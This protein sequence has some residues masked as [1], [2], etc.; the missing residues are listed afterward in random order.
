MF[1]Y[2]ENIA[3]EL[4]RLFA[5]LKSQRFLRDLNSE[6]FASKAA[7][8]LAELNG[9]AHPPAACRGGRAT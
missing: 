1:C 4:R 3:G 8:F 9:N 6:E 2:P 5:W 7:H